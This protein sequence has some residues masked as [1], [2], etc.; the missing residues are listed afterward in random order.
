MPF[1]PTYTANGASSGTVVLDV[2]I[3]PRGLVDPRPPMPTPSMQP[4]EAAAV[5]TVRQWEFEPPLVGGVPTAVITRVT[6]NFAQY[7]YVANGALPASSNAASTRASG[8]PSDFGVIYY[9]VC[10]RQDGSPG[11]TLSVNTTTDALFATGQEDALSL[12]LREDELDRLHDEMAARGVF[13]RREQSDRVYTWPEPPA[14]G[15]TNTVVA[16][17]IDVT[18]RRRSTVTL[19]TVPWMAPH[20]W[21]FDIRRHGIWTREYGGD[22]S[23]VSRPDHA[24]LLDFLERSDAVKRLSIAR[25]CP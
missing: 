15:A 8:R 21:F 20:G 22:T 19:K 24:V 11:L 4:F 6:V 9:H 12:G 14:E 7:R 17:G 10:P 2:T 3:S 1:F 16:D 5:D 13:E 18:V 23:R 25:E